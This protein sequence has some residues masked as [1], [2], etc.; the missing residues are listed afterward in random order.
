MIK[1]FSVMKVVIVTLLRVKRTDCQNIFIAVAR[2][3]TFVNRSCRNVAV[4]VKIAVKLTS[5]MTF[6]PSSINHRLHIS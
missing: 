2:K 6:L 3:V 4:V 5:K 1:T